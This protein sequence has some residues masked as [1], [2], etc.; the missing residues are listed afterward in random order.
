M[1]SKCFREY[2]DKVYLPLIKKKNMDIMDLNFRADFGEVLY[3]QQTQSKRFVSQYIREN[4][5]KI[6]DIK[7]KWTMQQIDINQKILKLSCKID[8]LICAA[9]EIA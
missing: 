3:L 9:F 1:N 7:V 5:K 4:L 8:Q 6:E 2:G